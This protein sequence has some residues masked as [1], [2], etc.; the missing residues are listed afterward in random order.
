MARTSESKSPVAKLRLALGLTGAEFAKL[1]GLGHSTIQHIESGDRILKDDMADKIHLATGFPRAWLSL[2]KISSE[3]VAKWKAGQGYHESPSNFREYFENVLA[4]TDRE[5]TPQLPLGLVERIEAV[6]YRTGIEGKN[7]YLLPLALERCLSE[8]ITRQGL[9]ES[10][11]DHLT[12]EITAYKSR[13]AGATFHLSAKI[14]PEA[15]GYE[16]LPGTIESQ[17]NNPGYRALKKAL[18]SKRSKG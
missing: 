5:A 18:S 2:D 16:D 3:Q 12:E 6:F 1:V 14:N 8:F 10:A 9:K 15:D 13:V 17:V 11:L 4:A 7:P